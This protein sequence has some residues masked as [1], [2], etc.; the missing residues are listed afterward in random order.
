LIDVSTTKSFSYQ[1]TTHA[2]THNSVSNLNSPQS[3][4]RSLRNVIS[5]ICAHGRREDFLQGGP[6]GNFPKIFSRG[7]KS[8]EICFLPLEI[9]KTTFS[10]Y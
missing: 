3:S 4:V 10:C 5:Q 6:G 1:H 2:V 7:V 9:E 8:G